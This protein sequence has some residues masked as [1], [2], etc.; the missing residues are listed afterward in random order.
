M[1][2][3]VETDQPE[4]M[5]IVLSSMW[6]E[7]INEA[8]RQFNVERPGADKDMLEEVTIKREPDIVDFKRLR[9]L[10]NYTDKGKWQLANLMKNW[11]SKQENAV[12][13][14]REELDSLSK[15]QQEVELKK[16]EILEEHRFE[17]DVYGGDKR[18]ISILD[19]NLKYLYQD[20]PT[21]K[22]DVVLQEKISVEGEYDTVVYWKQQAMNLEKLLEASLRREQVLM[23]KLQESIQKLEKQCTPVEELSQ[24]LNRAD[25]FLHFVLQNA[26]VVIGHQV[27]ILLF[28]LF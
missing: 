16:L 11:E 23:E 27:Y 3:E 25:N 9:E 19:E 15:Q 17:R 26:P 1:G 22:H 6:P 7:D 24:V 8:G 13:L 2:C 28:H 4:E 10:S 21:R 14:L 20:A 18:P 12:R 5:D